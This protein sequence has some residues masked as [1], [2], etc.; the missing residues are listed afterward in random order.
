M[1]SFNICACT[2]S[3]CIIHLALHPP[4]TC[5]K[6]PGAPCCNNR[7]Q[8]TRYCGPAPFRPTSQQ[9]QQQSTTTTINNNNNTL[10]AR[11]QN[12]PGISWRDERK[13]SAILAQRN[14]WSTQQKNEWKETTNKCLFPCN[15]GFNPGFVISN[16][17][18]FN[19]IHAS[20]KA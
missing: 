8:M 14:P 7:A 5:R 16:H 10:Y 19:D 3:V 12:C 20:T 2:N 15:S 4:R 18:V 6:T 17:L 11:S 13:K 1:L 9:Q